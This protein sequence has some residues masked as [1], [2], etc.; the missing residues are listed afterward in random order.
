MKTVKWLLVAIL[1][2]QAIQTVVLWYGLVIYPYEDDETDD[3][4][5]VVLDTRLFRPMPLHKRAGLTNSLKHERRIR[6]DP[7]ERF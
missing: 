1:L 4:G 2:M 3:G 6:G 7:P 5:G